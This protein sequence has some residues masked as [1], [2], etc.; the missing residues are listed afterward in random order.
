M[1]KNAIKRTILSMTLIGLGILVI[2][3]PTLMDWFH[4]VQQAKLRSAFSQDLAMLGTLEDSNANSLP[5]ADR[6]A[7]DQET[8]PAAAGT[9]SQQGDPNQGGQNQVPKYKAE[10]LL[11]I[12]SIELEQPILPDA[13]AKH[14]SQAP[15]SIKGTGKPWTSGNYVVAGHRSRTYGRHFNRLGELKVG[16]LA[17]VVDSKGKTYSYEVYEIVVVDQS[18]VSVMNSGETQELTLITCT[19]PGV[20]N[21]KTR[22]VVKAKLKT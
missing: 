7:G 13:T 22:L 19:P 2:L 10:A 5:S 1:N 4:D 8:A 9:Q 3:S 15:A 17:E 18:E 11:R 6:G 21:P 16:D 12:P 20:K 14:L